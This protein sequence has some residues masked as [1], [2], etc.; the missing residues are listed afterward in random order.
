MYRNLDNRSEVSVPV[1]DRELQADLWHYV[2]LQLRD[3]VK[4]R[5][6]NTKQDNLYV[7]SEQNAVPFRSQLKIAQWIRGNSKLKLTKT[8]ML[9]ISAN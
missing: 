9:S 6:L 7:P 8:D 4:A 3:N 2:S 1:Y 5:L